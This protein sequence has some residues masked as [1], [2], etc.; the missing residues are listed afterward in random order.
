MIIYFKK[1]PKP[2]TKPKID[3][4][5]F[6]LDDY[7]E[8]VAKTIKTKAKVG[9]QPS[10]YIW[11]TN[12]QV[13]RGNWLVHTIAYKVQTHGAIKD[14]CK[15][16]SK[17]KA[18][19]LTSIKDSKPFDK[20]RK[21]KKKKQHKAKQDLTLAPEV[22]K[23]E[24]GDH[25]KWKKD[26]S[27]IIYYNCRKKKTLFGQLPKA[28]KVKKL[29]LVLAT[30]TMMTSTRKKTLEHIHY[31][32]YPVWFKNTNKTQVQAVI[33]SRSKVNTIHPSFTK[34]LGLLIRQTDVGA[35]KIYSTTLDIYGMVI[36]AFAVME[37]VNQVRFF[38]KT[39]M[40]ANVS[41]EVVLEMLFLT[42]SNEDVDF[43]VWELWWRTYTT[44]EVFPT[45]RYIE[46]VGKIDFTAAAFDPKYKSFIVY[47]SSL[48]S[49]PLIAFLGSTSLNVHSFQR[50]QISNL[51]A[52]KTSTKISDKYAAFAEVFFLD[53]VNKL[54]KYIG[55][56]NCS[57]KLVDDQQPLYRPIYTLGPVELETLK[58]YIEI[59]LVNGSFKLSESHADAPILFD[60]KLDCS[61]RLYIDYQGLYN[62]TI[63]NQYPLPLIGESFAR[64]GTARQFT[65]FNLISAYLQRRI[66]K[67]DE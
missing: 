64:L 16:N 8:L 57:I 18:F 40:V 44:K 36:A 22:N 7:E 42:L 61:L 33:D 55:I 14:Y 41:P 53:L 9:I 1:C 26:V 47:I 54:P 31:I 30:S 66:H 48:N 67:G 21:D 32:H 52:N 56:N 15:N 23:A 62:L 5:A 29:V 39:F 60:R 49:M 38:E 37:K 4:D 28:L 51:I 2:F 6:Q 10:F 58:A 17:A 63:K 34:Q 43:S 11:E 12:Q 59:N 35:Q 13:P 46:L 27:E 3:Q 24:V 50:S 25:K 19:I 20:A 65:Q 45:I